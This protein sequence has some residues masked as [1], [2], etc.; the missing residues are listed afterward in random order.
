MWNMKGFDPEPMHYTMNCAF[1]KRLQFLVEKERPHN[2]TQSRQTTF[3]LFFSGFKCD[4]IVAKVLPQLWLSVENC[5]LLTHLWMNVAT[6]SVNPSID[7]HHPVDWSKIKMPILFCLIAYEPVHPKP[8]W[9]LSFL[10]SYCWIAN[11]YKQLI[12]SCVFIT[13]VFPITKRRS[14][15]SFRRCIRAL[16]IF[17]GNLLC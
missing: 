6:Y 13:S 8:Y 14:N 15:F 4:S 11:S 3:S 17:I 5:V 10:F 12:D 7:Y 9:L 2:P 1:I 16:F